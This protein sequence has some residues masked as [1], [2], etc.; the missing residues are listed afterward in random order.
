MFT[1]HP[2]NIRF[3]LAQFS[4]LTVAELY[5]I[6]QLREEVFV[7]EQNCPYLDCDDKDQK[8]WHCCFYIEE[9]L[10]G[11]TRLVP[12]VKKSIW[13]IG[14]VVVHPDFR[15]RALGKHI[16]NS[17]ID[18]LIRQLNCKRIELSAQTY[19]LSFYK[20]LGFQPIGESY[21]EDNIPH[22]KMIYNQPS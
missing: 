17:S 16:M 5:T 22:I 1:N 21:L 11:Y 3:K 19:L 18:I 4:D 15:N 8:S 12:T 9:K 20:D 7:V 10:A 13:Q 14:R 2:E 6:I